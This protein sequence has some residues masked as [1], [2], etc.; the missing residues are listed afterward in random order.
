M[1][2][3]NNNV[4]K[5]I[6]TLADELNLP[7][8]VVGGWVRDFYL[9]IPSDDIDIV[10]EGDGTLLAQKFAEKTGSKVSIFKNYGTA[11]VNYGDS[12]V[13]FVGA[14]SESYPFKESRN[15]VVRP[16]TLYEDLLRRDFTI[17]AMAI[18]IN[19]SRFGELVDPFN[20][21]KCLENKLIVTP[22]EPGITFSDDPLRMLR[23]I[24]FSTKLNFRIEDVTLQSI[25]NNSQRL[26]II[27][28]ERIM[29]EFFKILSYPN[30]INGIKLLQDTGLLVEFLPELSALDTIDDG[31][32]KNNFL[33]SIEVLGNVSA[34]PSIPT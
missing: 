3:L 22:T 31:K 16:G 15:P 18:C 8:Y 9:A 2:E 12:D 5:K 1:N 25:K 14:R 29:T 30:P 33:H 24:R 13:E 17:N 21:L 26:D 20:G 23:C 4:F 32:H 34:P 28:V 7:C 11:K 27:S 6:G 10:V 19:S